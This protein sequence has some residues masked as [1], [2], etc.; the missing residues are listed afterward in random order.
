MRDFR[1]APTKIL[2]R[3]ART[4]GTVRLGEFVLSVRE[5]TDGDATPSTLY[6]AMSATGR[7]VGSPADL[8]SANESWSTDE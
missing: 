6:G 8:L 4:G 2:R 3:A 5:D 7:V 1:A